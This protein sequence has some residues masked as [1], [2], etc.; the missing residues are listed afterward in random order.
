MTVETKPA[1]EKLRA[2]IQKLEEGIES[3]IDSESFQSYLR[4]MSRFHQYSTGNIALIHVQKPEATRV[5]G[6]KRWQELGRQVRKGERG[7][8]I[9]APIVRRI[10]D[11][12]G[13]EKVRVVANFRMTHV[14]DITQTD[15]E[16]LPE[17]PA[18]QEITQATD[19][20]RELWNCLVRFLAA[21]HVTV[22]VTEWEGSALG[23]YHPG[24]K[25]IAVHERIAGTDQGTKTL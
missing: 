19:P 6:Y 11:D 21:E 14:F 23:W 9:L 24:S 20:G 18:V 7:I 10:E 5:A 13:N 3:I 25:S 15:G 22:E 2:A 4:C 8:V 1:D 12:E 17:P 16:P